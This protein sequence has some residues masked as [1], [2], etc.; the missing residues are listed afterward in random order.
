[1]MVRPHLFTPD[2]ALGSSASELLERAY[3]FVGHGDMS[4]T[5]SKKKRD[6][7][8]DELFTKFP[9]SDEAYS[10]HFILAVLCF[11]EK[12]NNS[13]ITGD[14]LMEIRAQCKQHLMN[15]AERV[16]RAAH[17]LGVV[18]EF[19][20]KDLQSAK[21]WYDKAESQ[22]W[23]YNGPHGC[24]QDFGEKNV[25]CDEL[26]QR[27]LE[28]VAIATSDKRWGHF[29]HGY[30][31]D[32]YTVSD[33]INDILKQLCFLE[34]KR[35]GNTDALKELKENEMLKTK[36]EEQLWESVRW[37][38][39]MYG[40]DMISCGGISIPKNAT[41]ENVLNKAIEILDISDEFLYSESIANSAQSSLPLM[42]RLLT[43]DALSESRKNTT[44]GA[45]TELRF[46]PTRD[47]KNP[48]VDSAQE[49][50]I[51]Q[52]MGRKKPLDNIEWIVNEQQIQLKKKYL[53]KLLDSSRQ[54]NDV[55]I[56]TIFG[57][58]AVGKLMMDV[59]VYALIYRHGNYKV[60]R[61]MEE[62]VKSWKVARGILDKEAS[63]L[64]AATEYWLHCF[65]KF[66]NFIEHLEY[67]GG[68][69]GVEKEFD[70]S[71]D[72]LR[73][74]HEALLFIVGFQMAPLP[75][76]PGLSDESG[77]LSRL[78]GAGQN[79]GA[80]RQHENAIRAYRYLRHKAPELTA[81]WAATIAK[82][83]KEDGYDRYQ[84]GAKLPQGLR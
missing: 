30:R 31:P 54:E 38:D 13:P 28:K 1:M 33:T 66:D 11:K 8:L 74:S 55:A 2:K 63:V 3:R 35:E 39:S 79:D 73:Q 81:P 19:L 41:H 71:V 47:S 80:S 45:K 57:P 49:A 6:A 37:L 62:N 10:G 78:F 46:V 68:W 40:M 4:N 60:L 9:D 61:W 18:Y 12:K 53:V 15:A 5:G 16:P 76:W 27:H 69:D 82:Y 14:E 59:D 23:K 25:A 48:D 50:I 84:E 58:K 29:Y 70:N 43:L 22:G 56:L 52:M 51:L 36:S 17:L 26:P 7:A 21:Q 24:E 65:W 32:P 20:E 42:K 67:E 83:M 72:K 64:R 75:P 77:V 44:D 34:F